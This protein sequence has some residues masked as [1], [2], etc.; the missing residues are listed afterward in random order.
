[1]LASP[2]VDILLD[3]RPA[4]RQRSGVGEYAHELAAALGRTARPGDRLH[5]FTSSWADRPDRTLA[6]TLGA[7]VVDRRIPVRVLNWSWHRRGF[8]PVEWLAGRVDIAQS[9][10][11]LLIPARHARQVITIHDLDFLHHPERTTAEVRRD[12][13]A[14]VRHHA[15]R[16]ALVVVNSSDT[17]RA[18]QSQLGIPPDRIVECRPGL[19]GWIGTPVQRP[20]P[21]NGYVLFV[22]T[23]ER[24]KNIGALL[25]AWTLLLKAMPAVPRL[26]LMGGASPE[27]GTWLARLQV[28]PLLG[29]VE[30][31]GYVPD[32]QRRSIYSGARMLVLPSFHEGFGL[33]ALE[34]MAL[35][36]P[37]VASTAGALPEV[38]G[39]AGV[40]VAPDD[41]RGLSAAIAAV[42][43]SPARAADMSARGLARASTF[44]WDA[45]ARTLRDAFD[46]VVPPAPPHA[47]RD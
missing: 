7:R 6:A 23:L 19:P 32:A 8:P 3:Y 14:L 37:V 44:T 36:V 24:R 30:Y 16:A 11:P 10:S 13:P 17:S 25:D 39:D 29:H 34:A 31:V 22:G 28:P 1:V 4:L 35:G 9:L 18:V 41:V 46:R 20:E 43:S 42:L 5:L 40:L 45:A 2:A 26:R 27:A 47:H 12:Y 15:P 38:V 33:P 21:A